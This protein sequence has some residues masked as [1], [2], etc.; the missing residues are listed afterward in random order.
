MDD[1]LSLTVRSDHW[2]SVFTV[3]T[4]SIELEI[5]KEAHWDV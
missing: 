5:Q 3:A 1:L 2:R 4:V